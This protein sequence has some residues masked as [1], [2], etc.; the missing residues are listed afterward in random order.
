[1]LLPFWMQR[2]STDC[3]HSF[4]LLSQLYTL[5][6]PPSTFILPIFHLQWPTTTSNQHQ[7]I[8]N[9]TTSTHD[10]IS[11]SIPVTIWQSFKP[12]MNQG[13]V[14]WVWM[15][16][17]YNTKQETRGWWWWWKNL[18]ALFTCNSK[19]VG[20][21]RGFLLFKKA[22]SQL[23][24]LLLSSSDLLTNIDPWF[25]SLNW[26]I[27]QR[28]QVKNN[29]RENRLHFGNVRFGGERNKVRSISIDFSFFMSGHC[30]LRLK[31][32]L[33]LLPGWIINLLLFVS[34]HPL[35][36][37]LDLHLIYLQWQRVHFLNPIGYFFPQVIDRR[38]NVCF[39][40]T[41]KRP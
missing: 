10:T 17:L 21:W 8:P 16:A 31:I 2:D 40:S 23:K 11:Y 20:A 12:S 18:C 24:Q 41:G 13:K 36:P 19:T 37:Y 34:H 39:F 27:W 28:K 15:R 29:D 7:F 25:R 1:M 9:S 5:T 35:F 30:I 4:N 22:I 6:I 3:S 14:R 32:F 26:K 33:L 38:W